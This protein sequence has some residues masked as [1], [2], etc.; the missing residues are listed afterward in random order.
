MDADARE[1]QPRSPGK[2]KAEQYSKKG[3]T[4]FISSL[5]SVFALAQAAL[6]FD[7]VNMLTYLFT[8]LTGLIFGI[9]QMKTA[10]EYWTTEFL[11]YARMYHRKEQTKCLSLM[12][13]NTEI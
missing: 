3:I 2:W 9:L 5:L 12:E 13:K 4:I 10:E 8:I 6:S 7:Y 1:A 11:D